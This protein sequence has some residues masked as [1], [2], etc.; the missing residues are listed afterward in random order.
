M[1]REELEKQYEKKHKATLVMDCAYLAVSLY[2]GLALIGFVALYYSVTGDLQVCRTYYKE[3][4]TM[5]CFFSHKTVR[6]P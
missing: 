6:V 2:I 5:Q 3:M 1:T 4:S